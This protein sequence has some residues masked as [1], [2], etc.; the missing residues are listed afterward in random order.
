VRARGHLPIAGVVIVLGV[1]TTLLALAPAPQGS[2]GPASRITGELYVIAVRKAAPEKSAELTALIDTVRHQTD[3]LVVLSGGASKMNEAKQRELLA[4]FA[5]LGELAK[6]RRI[7]VG[8]GGTKAGIMEAAGTARRASGR[9][10]PL[11]GVAP[12]REIPP[13]GQTPIDPNHS[14]VVAVDD[15][16]LAK[17]EAGWG[18]ETATMYWLFG[19]MSEGRPSVAVVANGGGITLAEIDA[20]VEAGRP[21]ILIEGSG[22]AADAVI[23]LLHGTMPADG[24]VALMQNEAREA[25]LN[26]RPEL[27]RVVSIT[28]GAPGL[29]EALRAALGPAP[30]K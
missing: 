30:A 11:I 2:S 10:F 12:A 14:H 23:T 26:R 8:D 21:T 9:A 4:M 28:K 22:R 19:R 16:A 20:N 3:A 17:G 13:A 18:S 27:F 6:E 24:E 1:T 5:A 25:K 7:A 29:L 15:A